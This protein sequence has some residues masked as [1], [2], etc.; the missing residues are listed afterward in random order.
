ME[1]TTATFFDLVRDDLP[2]VEARMRRAPDGGP[3]RLEGAIEHLLKSGG[4][5]LRPTLVLLTGRMLSADRDSLVNLAASIEMLHT[6]TL[7]H[8]DLID[9]ALV[10]RGLPTLNA[11]WTAGATVLTG[12][13]VFARAAHLASQIGSLPLM[14][15]FAR[16]LMVI[17]QG[18]ITQIFRDGN[19][20]PRQA[21]YDRI[22]AKTASLFE[23]A[24]RGAAMLSPVGD[25]GLEA[26]RRFGYHL[27]MA[28]QIVDDALDFIGDAAQVGKPVGSDL[29]QGLITLP[30][31]CYAETQE[32]PDL[33][34]SL[35][36][37]RLEP[38]EMGD[39]VEAVR[40]SGA[41]DLAL[42]EAR[43]TTTIAETFL[44]GMPETPERAALYQAARYVVDRTL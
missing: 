30:T 41:V 7:V 16:T 36:N 21:Y 15:Q 11:Q 18:E 13:Y 39:L 32:R 26:M 19:P 31:L 23:M 35:Q 44:S 3:S 1:P 40:R 29:R 28:F 42:E 43:R 9:G 14:E 25:G 10:R 37:G 5:R 2:D 4:K 34:A 12:D 27:G 6:A 17:V 38:S 8:D 20:D 24:T 22:Y 33:V